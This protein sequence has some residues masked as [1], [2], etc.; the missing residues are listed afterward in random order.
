MNDLIE[1]DDEDDGRGNLAEQTVSELS[2]AIKRTVE[3]RF[4][5][6][7]VRGEVGRVSLPRSGHVYMSLKDDRSVIDGVMWKGVAARMPVRPEEGMEAIVTGRLTTFAGQSKYQIVIDH[8]APAGEGALMAMLEARKRALTAEGLFAAERKKPLPMMPRVIGVVTSPSGAVIRDI[9]HR[10]ADRFP[11]DVLVWPVAVQGEKCAAEVSA[12]IRGF[13]AIRPGGPVPRP[14]VLIVARGGGSIEDLW[15]FNEE[16]V[17]RAAADCSIPLISAVGHETDVTL[18][19]HA[20][21]LRAPTPTGAAEKAVPVRT[22]LLAALAD[23]NARRLRAMERNLNLSRERLRQSARLMPKPQALLSDLGQRLDILAQRLPRALTG[24][25]GQYAATL[26][27]ARARL[28]PSVMAGRLREARG[29]L[30]GA[31]QR[32]SPQRLQR[33]LVERRRILSGLDAMFTR[34]GER[35]LAP[36][37]ERIDGVSRMLEAVSYHRVLDRGFAVVRNAN[38]RILTDASE[39]KTAAPLTVELAAE[40]RIDVIVAGAPPPKARKAKK[41]ESDGNAPPDLF[42]ML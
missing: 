28:R 6:V 4:G 23:R 12:A 27:D 20:A 36:R 14:D 9:L 40:Q 24:S 34:T 42:S 33:D 8:F 39:A 11:C 16:I 10:L 1:R 13:D 31:S 3:D 15:G 30:R 21:D 7:R 22:E 18:I 38:G 25:L 35:L 17:V 26:S 37:R 32:L 5:L 2:G 19:D 41:A 29:T